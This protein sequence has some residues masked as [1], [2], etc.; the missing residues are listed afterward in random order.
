MLYAYVYI[1][2]YIYI[3][4]HTS[5][6]RAGILIFVCAVF[7]RIL[8][9]RKSPQYLSASLNGGNDSLRRYPQFSAKLPK[10]L[11][12]QISKSWLAKFPM[13]QGGEK[14]RT[15]EEVRRYEHEPPSEPIQFTT[16]CFVNRHET[17]QVRRYECEHIILCNII[18]YDKIV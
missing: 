15:V 14:V 4:T 3:Y 16:D 18:V 2:I 9:L 6:S 11:R 13:R 1:Y 5:L 12:R 17:V 8:R 10:Q 7:A